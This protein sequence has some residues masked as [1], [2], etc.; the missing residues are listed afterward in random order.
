VSAGQGAN[1]ERGEAALMIGG[2]RLGFTGQATFAV[3]DKSG[4]LVASTTV[5]FDALGPLAT[6]DDALAAINGGLAGNASV[7]L[8]DGSLSSIASMVAAKAV[9][10]WSGRSSR[11]TEVS[12]A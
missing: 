9:E 2:D 6:V 11:F 4:I 12:T 8:Q 10:P 1:P 5:D 7:S 3:T